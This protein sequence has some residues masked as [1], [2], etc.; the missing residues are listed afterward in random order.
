MMTVLRE[1]N[2]VKQDAERVQSENKML[3]RTT[4]G[5][6]YGTVQEASCSMHFVDQ[7]GKRLEA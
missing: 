5:I 4:K 1:L 3:Q 2:G 6:L 7:L